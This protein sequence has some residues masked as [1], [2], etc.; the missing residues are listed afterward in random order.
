MGERLVFR[1]FYRVVGVPDT[2]STVFVYVLAVGDSV[3]EDEVVCEIET[4][5]VA[6]IP[7]SRAQRVSAA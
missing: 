5:K 2:Y 7:E 3:T 4:D 1:I 6:N